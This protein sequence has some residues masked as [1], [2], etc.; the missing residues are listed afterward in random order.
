[1]RLKQRNM[2]LF[3][4]VMLGSTVTFAGG[5][6]HAADSIQVRVE[7]HMVRTD[8]PPVNDDGTTMIELRPIFEALGMKV[9]WNDQTQ[10][11]T[12]EG[13]GVKITF[14]IGD[15]ATVINGKRRDMPVSPFISEGHVM[16][17]LR[18]LG[19]A[20]GQHV[21]WN[22][23]TKLIT[24]T[25]KIKTYKIFYG[26][27]TPAIIEQMKAYDLVVIEPSVYRQD[28]IAAIKSKG[29]IVIGYQSIMEIDLHQQQ[30]VDRLQDSDY[31]HDKNGD[32]VYFE[33]WRSYLADLSKSHLR[34]VLYDQIELGI[35]KKGMDGVFLDTVDHID[36]YF[37]HQT[38]YQE[39]LR[40]SYVELLKRLK[41]TSPNLYL[42]QNN[43]FETLESASLP[44]VSGVLWEN[45]FKYSTTPDEWTAEWLQQLTAIKEQNGTTI[46]TTVPNKEAQYISENIGFPTII[47][48]D[49]IYNTW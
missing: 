7:N 13:K 10:E 38:D 28:Q 3:M 35:V 4:M 34:Q 19:E 29:T 12:G 21:A 18:I 27:P 49:S 44:Y 43:G 42:I 5:K 14:R 23:D 48:K 46:F 26:N 47:N 6:A 15:N 40:S 25:K 33:E 11:A 45:L 32:T 16:V 31:F 37:A 20:C 17:P 2:G 41:A 36:S 22:G 8:T 39:R 30:Y 24:L 1:M 9:T